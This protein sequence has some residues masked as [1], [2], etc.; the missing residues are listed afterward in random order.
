MKKRRRSKITGVLR[1]KCLIENMPDYY[2]HT[3]FYRFAL[4]RDK[5]PAAL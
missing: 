3:A 4:K 5:P 2:K 1:V